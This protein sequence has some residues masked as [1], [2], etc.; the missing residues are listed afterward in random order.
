[1]SFPNRAPLKPCLLATCRSCSSHSDLD[2]RLQTK[3]G[4]VGTSS[5]SWP[6]LHLGSYWQA[7]CN[8]SRVTISQPAGR[9][10]F[11]SILFQALLQ[12]YRGFQCKP[13]VDF[14][15]LRV[16]ARE[17]PERDKAQL[18]LRLV[19]FKGPMKASVLELVA[20]QFRTRSLC[21]R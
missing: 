17:K 4:R 7:Y 13:A 2:R 18:R 9:G 3:T 14:E 20:Y 15:D 11:S 1:M 19:L 5:E 10:T 8:A 21:Q 16:R 6:R 12:L